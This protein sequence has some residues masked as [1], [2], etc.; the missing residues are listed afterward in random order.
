MN[1]DR[2]PFVRGRLL[3]AL[4]LLIPAAS[5]CGAASGAGPSASALGAAV[6]KGGQSFYPPHQARWAGTVGSFELCVRR[7]GMSARI[8][9]VVA[10]AHPAVRPRSVTVW[11]RSV[12]P[13]DVARVAPPRRQRFL[14]LGSTLGE[15][16]RWRHS[17]PKDPP[18]RYSTKVSGLLIRQTCREQRAAQSALGGGRVP[19]TVSHELLLSFVVDRRGGRV[20]GL[21]VHYRD[22]A[23]R[24]GVLRE[25]WSITACGTAIHDVN[26]CPP[27][28]SG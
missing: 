10:R 15:P 20:D 19:R 1:S 21:D 22:G 13:A 5:A 11:D 6:V 24:P 4:M 17:I 18:G 28:A 23:G 2:R 27:G 3:V 16:P 26:E 14:V 7:D 12:V 25:R 9:K 8:T